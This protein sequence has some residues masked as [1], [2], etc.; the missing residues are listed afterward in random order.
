[1]SGNCKI[2]E[3]GILEEITGETLRP[4]GYEITKEALSFCQFPKGA[5]ILD[6]GCGTGATVRFLIEAWG[7][8][9]LG[10]DVS[11]EL[12]RKGQ[13]EFSALP[14]IP[15]SGENLPVAGAEMDGLLMECSFSL[16]GNPAAVLNECRRVLKKNGKLI[17]SDFYYKNRPGKNSKEA[18]LEML[19]QSGFEV[20]L[21][22]DKSQYI[23]QLLFDAIMNEKPLDILWN[24]MLEKEENQ[25]LSVEQIKK[26]K[27]GYFLLIA[28]KRE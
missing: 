22:E 6:V 10:I 24:C 23:V 27:P 15:G 17:I 4:G 5:R 8:D 13:T 2:Y 26:Y 9:A 12:I 11:Q 19:D 7:M 14:L 21:W 25:D 3:K 18:I 28:V 20:V 1:M 16:M